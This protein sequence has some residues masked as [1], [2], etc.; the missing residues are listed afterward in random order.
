MFCQLKVSSCRPSARLA[1]ITISAGALLSLAAAVC[2]AE[3]VRIAAGP[4]RVGIATADIT[5]KEPVGMA[6]FG[7]R[8][9][10]SEGV[11]KPI[12]AS[13]VVFDNTV[14]RVAF[15]AFDLCYIGK[16][17]L[18]DL[19]A[20]AQKA[21]IPPQ[22]LMVNFSHTHSGPNV[23]T[24]A[25]AAYAERFKSLTDALFAQA[26]ADLQPALLDYTVGS[27]TMAVSRRRLN[28]KRHLAEML[29]E[30]RKPIDPDV[31]ILR[32]T[33]P[34]GKVRAVLFGY[35]C[36]PS[37]LH[38][39]RISPDY[40]GYARDWIVAVYPGC[41]PIFFQGC[42]GDIKTRCVNGEGIFDFPENLL[43]PDAFTAELGHELGRAVVAAL[44]VPPEPAPADRSKVPPEAFHAPPGARKTPA[45]AY[46][47]PPEALK[48]L[49]EALK[50]PVQLA[51]I[52]EEY[53][54]PDKKEPDKRSRKKLTGAWR[55]GDVYLVGMQCEIGSQ[56]GLR[57]K[58]DMSGGR[59]WT[60]GYTHHGIGYFVDAASY[61]EKGYEIECSDV[62]PE[63]EDILVATVIRQVRALKA[64][65]T[66]VGPCPDPPKKQ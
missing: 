37:T 62:A 18:D 50:T 27:S 26:A 28:E 4:L 14:T 45:A 16:T 49:S 60:C 52:V 43:A 24:P 11:G 12:A 34:E 41:V 9:H 35:A 63:A 39:Y 22:Q 17:Q 30:P 46:K 29:P 48:A 65:R 53:D 66:G 25:N 6:G 3:T 59:V 31:P 55:V 51:G 21:K 5:P 42:A 64:G 2:H 54:A 8:K 13:C 10:P 47:A 38:D 1:A 58:R 7:F 32:V 33:S 44:S 36:H 20:A 19:R 61:S 56:I 23:T 40:V 15:V 57:L